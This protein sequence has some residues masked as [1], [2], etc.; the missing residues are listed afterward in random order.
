M[1][2][3]SNLILSFTYN[4]VCFYSIIMRLLCTEH[5]MVTFGFKF[6][7]YITKNCPC[8]I[9]RFFQEAKIDNSIG[10][11]LFLFFCIFSLKTYI[12]GTR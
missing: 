4:M 5:C 10:K 12:V 9:Q 3:V 11:N 1:S 2:V 6:N 8:N 7:L